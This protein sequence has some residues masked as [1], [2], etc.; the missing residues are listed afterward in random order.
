MPLGIPDRENAN[1]KNEIVIS[2]YYL[3]SSLI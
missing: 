1:L 3:L 2:K